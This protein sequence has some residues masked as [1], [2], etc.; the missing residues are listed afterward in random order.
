MIEQQLT[1]VGALPLTTSQLQSTQKRIYHSH[2]TDLVEEL[3][4][5]DLVDKIRQYEWKEMPTIACNKANKK[6]KTKQKTW[7]VLQYRRL[8]KTVQVG[9]KC[10]KLNKAS[11]PD[12]FSIGWCFLN[13]LIGNMYILD[14]CSARLL[15]SYSGEY[16]E[17]P[18]AVNKET[19]P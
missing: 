14:H 15:D 7:Q 8:I 11:L 13:P 3:R 18:N 10:F 17:K 5:T 19:H 1:S 9:V 2:S 16:S 12:D 4:T 6:S